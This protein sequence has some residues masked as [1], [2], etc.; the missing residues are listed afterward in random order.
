MTPVDMSLCLLSFILAKDAPSSPPHELAPPTRIRAE[1]AVVAR[2]LTV[3][4]P[5]TES[6]LLRHHR[7]GAARSLNPSRALDGTQKPHSD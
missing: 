4:A 1:S 7:E 3:K 6:Y 5:L 2:R